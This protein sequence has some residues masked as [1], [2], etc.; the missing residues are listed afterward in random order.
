MRYHEVGN[1]S[2]E[3]VNNAD[4]HCMEAV[5]FLGLPY[6]TGNMLKQ[7]KSLVSMA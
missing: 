6:D 2:L 5:G 1:P 3:V 4:F 7:V